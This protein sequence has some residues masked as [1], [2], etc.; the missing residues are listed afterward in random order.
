MPDEA[1]FGGLAN[2]SAVSGLLGR[3]QILG[4]NPLIVCD[5]GHNEDG[6]RAIVQQLDNMA[7]KKLHIVFGTVGD[8][9]PDNILALLPE[10]AVY[11]FAKANIAR[12]MDV[13]TLAKHATKFKLNGEVYDSVAEAFAGAKEKA[14]K[15]D[16]IFVGG[17]TFVV[18]EIL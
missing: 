7:Y 13:R 1:L 2:V 9:D 18:A 5:T 16:L 8:K 15:H 6:I 4:N 17:S 12:A 14:E 10:N 11:Y 3:W